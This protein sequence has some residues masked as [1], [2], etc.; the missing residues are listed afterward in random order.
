MSG[1]AL[2]PYFGLPVYIN[3]IGC[4]VELMFAIHTQTAI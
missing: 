2:Y 1:V 4:R 3:K